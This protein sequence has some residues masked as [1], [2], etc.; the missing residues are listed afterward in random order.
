MRELFDAINTQLL[1]H[2]D[3]LHHLYWLF[4]FKFCC[5]LL[6]MG[7]FLFLIYREDWRQWTEQRNAQRRCTEHQWIA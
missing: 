7:V 6:L 2:P 4:R 3:L 1:Q 5:L